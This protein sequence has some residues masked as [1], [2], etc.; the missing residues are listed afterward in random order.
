[1]ALAEETHAGKDDR[2]SSNSEPGMQST[3]GSAEE[4]AELESGEAKFD[5]DHGEPAAWLGTLDEISESDAL[6]WT[7]DTC[8]C[9]VEVMGRMQAERSPNDQCSYPEPSIGPIATESGTISTREVHRPAG[10]EEQ[11]G[12]VTSIVDAQFQC[13]AANLYLLLA[14]SAS[15]SKKDSQL[16]KQL[17]KANKLCNSS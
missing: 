16:E 3:L 6:T 12:L 5:V 7:E 15:S 4:P 10:V 14:T 2:V 11:Q 13:E 1:M 9:L 8:A 17:R